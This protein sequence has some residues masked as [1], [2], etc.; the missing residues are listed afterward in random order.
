MSTRIYDEFIS[1]PVD[2]GLDEWISFMLDDLQLGDVLS[3]TVIPILESMKPNGDPIQAPDQPKDGL[4]SHSPRVAR[5]RS[6]ITSRDGEMELP[7]W[8]DI[9]REP[10]WE[11]ESKIGDPVV[12][13]CQGGG[14]AGIIGAFDVKLGDVVY[15]LEPNLN[16]ISPDPY[17]RGGIYGMFDCAHPEDFTYLFPHLAK[18]VPT[19]IKFI[20]GADRLMGEFVGLASYAVGQTIYS[21]GAGTIFENP[22]AF[23]PQLQKCW[24]EYITWLSNRG[25]R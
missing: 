22:N 14:G 7:T 21:H 25:I 13:I 3:N 8:T 9:N 19:Q 17:M 2:N 24:K 12:A 1:A 15:T 23:Y 4:S 16:A 6:N 5:Y 20:V 18:V 11:Y 10:L